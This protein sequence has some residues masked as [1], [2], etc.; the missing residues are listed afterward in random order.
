M[1]IYG[2]GNEVISQVQNGRVIN[3]LENPTP[4][5]GMFSGNEPSNFLQRNGLKQ[6]Q[7]PSALNQAFFSK[8]NIQLLQDMVRYNVWLKS[9][10]KFVIGA[11]STIELEIIARA[12]FLQNA[13]NL[14]FKIKEQVEELNWMVVHEVIPRIISEIE[15]YNSYLERVENLYIPIDHP[16]NINNK[17]TRLLR[18]VTSTF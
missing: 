3:I 18:S 17:G 13:R 9:G 15:Q 8:E 5:Y 12:I 7:S 1:A 6:I 14:P 11:Q 16:K 10:K 2:N 4:N